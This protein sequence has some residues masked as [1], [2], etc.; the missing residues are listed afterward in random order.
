MI[1]LENFILYKE[2]Q[3]NN[4]YLII[5][6]KGWPDAG[7][8]ASGAI[9][10]LKNKLK[11]E[12]FAEIKAEEFYVFTSSRP[13]TKIKE[14]KVQELEFPSNQFFF[15]KNESSTPDLI[16]LIGTE[17]DLKW[18]KYVK[19]LMEVIRKFM[20]KKIFTFGGVYANIPYSKEVIT[21]VTNIKDPHLKEILRKYEMET[22]EYQGPAGIHTLL[23][24]ECTR[25][26]ID[27][28]SLWG[29]APSY[30]GG[31]WN[32]KVSYALL[33]KFLKI[34]NL[35]VDLEDLKKKSEELNKQID[36][37]IEQK[38]ELKEY[39]KKLEEEYELKRP[40]HQDE[41]IK[42]IENFL[43]KHKN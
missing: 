4:P 5:G 36:K 6:F 14:G 11:A 25:K 24:T 7:K 9:N 26:G 18:N 21:I 29:N 33:K 19:L 16:L 30:I 41:L 32:L 42:E 35:K 22:G 27:I 13:L 31:I 2:P 15:W 10:Y 3:I 38:P 40:P 43:K 28:L 17:P 20:V 8:V 23:L 34:L 1:K 12:K 39:V 37:I